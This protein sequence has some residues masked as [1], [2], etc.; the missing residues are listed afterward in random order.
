MIEINK[1][2]LGSPKEVF[3]VI[4]E[5]LMAARD[6]AKK[7]LN[8]GISQED[9]MVLSPKDTEML[10]STDDGSLRI[11][12]RK[13]LGL[14]ELEVESMYSEALKSGRYILV[15]YVKEAEDAKRKEIEHL[16]LSSGGES[17]HYFGTLTFKPIAES[18]ATL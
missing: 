8:L 14:E 7:A 6:I 1:G 4:F 12:F 9:I 10:D 11:G 5:N 2:F 16:L 15:I 13:M 17:P 3:M 18:T